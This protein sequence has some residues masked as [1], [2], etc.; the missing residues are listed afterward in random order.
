MS[1]LPRQDGKLPIVGGL[2]TIPEYKHLYRTVQISTSTHLLIMLKRFFFSQKEHS[3]A[4]CEGASTQAKISSH[5]TALLSFFYNKIK[6]NHSD[7]HKYSTPTN[8]PSALKTIVLKSP[9]GASSTEE[10]R[11]KEKQSTSELS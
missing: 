3:A 11:K 10:R 1:I 5:T 4:Y 9:D 6:K 7:I 2:G 8:A